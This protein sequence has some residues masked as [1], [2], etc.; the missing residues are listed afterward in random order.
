MQ[1]VALSLDTAPPAPLDRQSYR[2]AMS[3]LAAAVNVVTTDGP[4]GRAGFTATAVCSVSDEPPT[5]LVC[6]NRSASA[7]AAVIGN[8]RLCVNVLSAEQSEV[9]NLFGGKTP[10]AERFAAHRWATS[11]NG[12]PLLAGAAL[13]FD[14]R[15]A[16]VTGVATHDVLFCEVLGVTLAE[17]VDALLYFDRRYHPLPVSL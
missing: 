6:L 10:M 15:I 9:S 13:A 3:R 2:D 7:H 8:G 1:A 17:Q 5:L 11:A 16:Q 14:C 12:S 4:F